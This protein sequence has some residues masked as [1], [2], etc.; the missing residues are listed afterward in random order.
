MTEGK[1]YRIVAAHTNDIYIGSTSL[2]YHSQRMACHRQN[3]KKG[4]GNYGDLFID[5]ENSPPWIEVLETCDV[6]HNDELRKKERKYI[7]D[8]TNAINVRCAYLYPEEREQRRKD[9]IKKYQ[10]SD[11]GKIAT[12]KSYHNTT[13]KRYKAKII[14]LELELKDQKEKTLYWKHEV[15]Q[16][17]KELQKKLQEIELKSA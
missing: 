3:A 14:E 9:C 11:K 16:R 13:V 12:A 17:L 4:I 6:S 5:M 7:E 2:E 1:I 10:A 15:S 8:E